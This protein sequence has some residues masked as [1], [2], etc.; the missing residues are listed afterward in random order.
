[1][2]LKMEKCEKSVR[3][4]WRDHSL[5]AF[6]G[7]GVDPEVRKGESKETRLLRRIERRPS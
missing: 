1:M 7:R 4:H 5:C 6:E 2:E 3:W